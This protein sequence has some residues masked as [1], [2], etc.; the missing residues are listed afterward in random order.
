M[1]RNF[2]CSMF[3][4]RWSL[5]LRGQKVYDIGF[6][7]VGNEAEKLSDRIL[8]TLTFEGYYKWDSY[9]DIAHDIEQLTQ[10]AGGTCFALKVGES[11]ET[12]NR[13]WPKLEGGR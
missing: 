4:A 8:T 11:A 9:P 6:G 12:I 13:E 7:F 10:L 3:L 1:I 5:R 2:Q